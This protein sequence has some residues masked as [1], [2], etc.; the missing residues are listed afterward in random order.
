[1]LQTIL[2]VILYIP[3]K[4][5]RHFENVRNLES[6]NAKLKEDVKNRDLLLKRIEYESNEGMKSNCLTH[7]AEL[8]KI[9]KLAQTFA[10]EQS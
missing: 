10:P 9:K 6:E 3:R 2:D 8:Q 4:I 7:Y 1:M 5:Y